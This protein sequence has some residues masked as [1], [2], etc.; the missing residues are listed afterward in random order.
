MLEHVRAMKTEAVISS[1]LDQGG[2]WVAFVQVLQH[3]LTQVSY[4]HADSPGCVALQLDDLICTGTADK[5]KGKF[6]E[7]GSCESMNLFQ[8]VALVFVF[9]GDC[10]VL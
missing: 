10:K 7:S 4:R 6:M 3:A 5:K 2:H 8:L 9:V 1:H